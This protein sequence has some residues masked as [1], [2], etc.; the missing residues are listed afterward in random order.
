MPL[1]LA[2]ALAL[3]AAPSLAQEIDLTATGDASAGES[4]FRQCVACH[5]VVNEAG[6]TLAGRSGRTGPN[7][8]GVAGRTA[9]SVEGFR[10]SSSLADAGAAGLVWD[11]A[12]FAAFVQD[13]TAF[14]RETLGS[15]SARSK[16]TVKV[17]KPEDA[18]NL[19]AYLQYL[20]DDSDDSDDSD[21]ADE[22]EAPS[23]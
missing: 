16:M 20:A 6:D 2:A 23:N 18:V 8:Y 17:R 11:E 22:S 4:A 13:P 19:Y 21:E 5:V 7:L 10:Y 12:S 9:G 1:K 14:L 15:S 3:I